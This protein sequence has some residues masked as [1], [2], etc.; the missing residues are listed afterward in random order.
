MKVIGKT[1]T[2]NLIVEL[3]Q[4]EFDLIALLVKEAGIDR[5]STEVASERFAS[6]ETDWQIRYYNVIKELNLSARTRHKLYRMIGLWE[7]RITSM[8]TPVYALFA[9]ETKDSIRFLEPNEWFNAVLS[10]SKDEILLFQK[11]WGEGRLKELIKAIEE[12]SGI[13]D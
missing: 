8:L 12:Y 11:G 9:D 5:Q 3:T 1:S 4:K 7:G 2:D 6:D 10:G 13:H